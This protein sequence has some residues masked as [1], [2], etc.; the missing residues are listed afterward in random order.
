MRHRER[1]DGPPTEEI[2]RGLVARAQ[3]DESVEVVVETSHAAGDAWMRAGFTEVARVLVGR[4]YALEQQLGGERGASFG[5]IHVQTDDVDAVKRAVRQ[6]VPRLPGR[7]QGSVVVPP[8]DGWTSV[9][10]EL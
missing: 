5:S 9:Y 10:D 3:E 7:S 4:V 1:L 2:L 8:R 6:F